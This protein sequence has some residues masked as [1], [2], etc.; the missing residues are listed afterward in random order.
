VAL[1]L[2]HGL[3]TR[4]AARPAA[5]PPNPAAAAAA[6]AAGARAFFPCHGWLTADA[7]TP[8]PSRT[9]PA[10]ADAAVTP[11]SKLLAVSASAVSP[12]TGYKVTFYTR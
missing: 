10:R 3:R 5:R 1:S 4:L 6:A 9:I 11:I 8:A 7:A 2:R 12:A